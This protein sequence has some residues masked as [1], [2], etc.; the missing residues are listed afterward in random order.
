MWQSLIDLFFPPY[1]L[2]CSQVL[3]T[4][5]QW[6]CTG[7]WVALPQ[8]DYHL[9]DDNS[10]ARKFHGRFPV[11]HVMAFGTYSDGNAVQKLVHQLKYYNKPR[12]GETLGRHYGLILRDMEWSK[13]LDVIIPV[14]LHKSKLRKR[15][16]NQ[17][18]GFAKGLSISLSIPWET[19]A[20]SRIRK[21]KPQ[22]SKGRRA[23]LVN[24]EGA[25]EVTD[26]QR[27]QNKHILLVDDVI[28]T[29]A[30]MEACALP[31]LAAGAKAISLAAIGTGHQSY[32]EFY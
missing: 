14:P 28:T 13:H 19:G 7:C 9:T 6:L 22:V 29:G 24:I 12:I 1:C 26:P 10:L 4:S 31:L 8:T 2:D 16:Y 3:V 18:D 15:G 27:V 23:R 25:F 5:E 20:L 21:T 17:S 11:A 30:T 32:S